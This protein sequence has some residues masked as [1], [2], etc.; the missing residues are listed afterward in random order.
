MHGAGF[1]NTNASSHGCTGT[2]EHTAWIEMRRR[3]RALNRRTTKDY[4]ERGI[5]VCPEWD[6]DFLT[7][8]ADMGQKP[9]PDHTLERKDNVGNYEPSNCIWA[10][11]HTQARNRRNT[12]PVEFACQTMALIDACA[13]AE[14]P[15]TTIE[16]RMLRQG[17]TFYQALA[18][19]RPEGPGRRAQW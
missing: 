11:M 12:L 14:V 15:Y 17:L 9:T 2:P 8:L 5:V 3:C 7:F 6:L 13:L 18:Y 16:K 1:G 10:T 19:V 4:A